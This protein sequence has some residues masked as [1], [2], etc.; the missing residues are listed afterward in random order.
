M[1]QI[2]PKYFAVS[3]EL[4]ESL[5]DIH[6]PSERMVDQ[7]TKISYRKKSHLKKSFKCNLKTV[8]KE[9]LLHATEIL[10]Q[11]DSES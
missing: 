11:K 6:N 9:A 3:H 10:L 1:P 7:P 5:L 8:I 2:L 4:D